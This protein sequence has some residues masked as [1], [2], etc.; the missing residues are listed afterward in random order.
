MTVSLIGSSQIYSHLILYNETGPLT[1]G[2]KLRFLFYKHTHSS[3]EDVITNYSEFWFLHQIL[4]VML[5]LC[6]VRQ[7]LYNM[8]NRCGHNSFPTPCYGLSRIEMIKMVNKY[9]YFSAE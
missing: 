8:L 6:Q 7:L 4:G 3:S 1:H 2:L 5:T 9:A